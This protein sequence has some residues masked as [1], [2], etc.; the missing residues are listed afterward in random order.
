MTEFAQVRGCFRPPAEGGRTA[1]KSEAIY[2]P[3]ALGLHVDRVSRGSACGV[4]KRG[5]P[6]GEKRARSE[7][8]PP[9][10]QDEREEE[11]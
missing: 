2:A 9:P 3:S 5:A 1:H 8:R 7:G 6:H 10:G 4:A 11:P